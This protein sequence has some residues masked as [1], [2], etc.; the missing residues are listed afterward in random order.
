MYKT[1]DFRTRLQN[2]TLEQDFMYITLMTL[3][4]DFR[5]RLYT[6]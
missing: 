1:K 2:K 4:Q 5:T 3:E 6:K